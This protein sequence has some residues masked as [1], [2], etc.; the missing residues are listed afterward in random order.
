MRIVLLSVLFAASGCLV[1]DDDGR[2]S[3]GAEGSGRGECHNGEDDDGDG[4]VDCRDPD[5]EEAT[6]CAPHAVDSGERPPED[7]GKDTAADE[8]A[9]RFPPAPGGL[10]GAAA[11]A[12]SVVVAAGALL[13]LALFARKRE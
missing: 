11:E 6:N 3:R 4:L 10:P 5:C 2:G 1:Y 9:A 8:E 12:P 13:S 7:S